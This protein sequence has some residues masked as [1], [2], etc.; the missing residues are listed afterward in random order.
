MADNAPA[1]LFTKLIVDDEE[2]MTDY[3]C[4]VYGLN[5][6]ARVGGDAGGMGEPFREVILGTGEAMDGGQTLVM[7]NFLDRPK[8]RDQQVILGFVTDDLDA[9]KARIV[10]NGGKP[11]GD[12]FEQTDHGVRVLFAEDPEGALTENVQML[13]H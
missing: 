3:Y 12:I 4:A 1:S 9:L 5:V 8:P 2:K 6:V 11:M 10:A 7:F 13:A